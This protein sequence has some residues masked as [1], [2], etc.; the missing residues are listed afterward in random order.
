MGRKKDRINNGEYIHGKITKFSNS[1]HI[2]VPKD[3]IGESV[4][5]FKYGKKEEKVS[6][7]DKMVV[8]QK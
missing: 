7:K 6:K 5:V 4:L 2:I 3:W 8:V 1:G